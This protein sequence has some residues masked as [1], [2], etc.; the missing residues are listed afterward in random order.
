MKILFYEDMKADIEGSIKQVAEYLNLPC[1]D[2]LLKLVKEKSSFDYMKV[3]DRF[4]T[5]KEI[6]DFRF[7]IAIRIDLRAAPT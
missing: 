4:T 6:L 1:D 5:K 2:Q 3:G 7:L